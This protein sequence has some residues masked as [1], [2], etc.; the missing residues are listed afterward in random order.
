MADFTDRARSALQR[1]IFDRL[2]KTVTFK[3]RTSTSYNSRGE[4]EA[5][6]FTTTSV[7]CVPYSVISNTQSY[8]PFGNLESGDIDAAFPYTVSI[9]VD[10][11]LTLESVDYRVKVIDKTYGPGH[12][13]TIARLARQY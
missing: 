13:A 6:T 9:D 2:G 1:T 5:E 3:S 12:I 11:V 4:Q 10:D 8:E 7:V